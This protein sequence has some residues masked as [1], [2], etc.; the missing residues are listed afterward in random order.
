MSDWVIVAGLVGTETGNSIG[1]EIS[2]DTNRAM[3]RPDLSPP[4]N[5]RFLLR[6]GAGSAPAGTITYTSLNGDAIGLT[7]ASTARWWTAQT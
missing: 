3:S 2:R 6:Y 4:A 5:D 7:D 1:V